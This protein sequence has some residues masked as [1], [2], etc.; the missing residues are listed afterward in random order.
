MTD[1]AGKLSPADRIRLDSKLERMRSETGAELAVF[2]T[3][4][5]DGDSIDDVA[6]Q[7]FSAWHLGQ[8]G[9]DDGVLLLVAPTERKVRIET[10]KGVG[11]LLTDVQSNEIIR[12]RVAPKLKNDRTYEALDDGTSAIAAA[13][14][15]G[16]H[17]GTASGTPSKP[18]TGG[19][20]AFGVFAGLFGIFLVLLPVLVVLVVVFLIVR[21]FRRGATGSNPSRGGDTNAYGG[22]TTFG[23]SS[24][25]DTYGSSGSDWS[26][27]DSSSSSSDS[28]S[29]D[30]GFSGGGGES[31]GGGSSD[32]Y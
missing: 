18:R 17:S 32:S 28:S 3:K 19:E 8:K 9:K 15:K 5:L 23:G 6:F 21:I 11:G 10:G 20:S 27:S 16:S 7:P 22:F 30:S 2:V 13:L 4:R 31:G 12:L 25:G 14:A 26:S 29:S 1:T 24:G